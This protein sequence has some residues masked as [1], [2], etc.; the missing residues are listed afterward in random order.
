M[1][2][3]VFS[4]DP[5]SIRT[6]WAVMQFPEQL[7]EAGLILPDKVRAESEFRIAAMCRDLRQ[8]LNKW[9]PETIVIEWTSGKVGRRRH[10]GGGA[11]LA[12]YGI[13]IGALWQ[14]CEAWRC[15]LPIEQQLDV[16]ILLIR[17]NVWT[18]SILK[19]DR[20]AAVASL[21]PEYKVEQ[22]TGGDIADALGLG[23]WY[24]RERKVRLAAM[25]SGA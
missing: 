25:V 6:G 3:I 12:I 17:E 23:L 15:S 9:Q 5:G 14:T 8:L 21:F 24:L 1:D 11:G 22:D 18:N 16:K 10:K 13:S 20:A 7:I 2:D 4:L 19:S